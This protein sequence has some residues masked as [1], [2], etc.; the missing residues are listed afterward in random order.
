MNRPRS[1]R[2]SRF[3]ILSSLVAVAAVGCSTGQSEP[4][5]TSVAHVDDGSLVRVVSV[6]SGKVLDV[7]GASTEDGSLVQQ[8]AYGGGENQKWIIRDAGGG[9]FT[10]ASVRSGKCLDVAGASRDDGARLQQWSCSGTPNQG[11]ALHP[12]P[13][14]SFE[15][16]AAGSE[17]CLDLS[18]ANAADGT[19][20]QQWGCSGAANQRWRIESLGAPIPSPGA[21]PSMG[22][23]EVEIASAASGKVLDVSGASAANGAS[24][25]QWSAWGGA[26]QRWRIKPA[27][28][29]LYTITSV[30]H[31]ECLDVAGA[32]SDDGARL[33]QWDCSGAPNQAFRLIAGS[34]GAYAISSAASDKCL[35]LPGGGTDDGLFVQQWACSGASN[36][37]WLLRAAAGMPSP[38][39]PPQ[40]VT[41]LRAAADR[42]GR[43][44]GTALSPS[45][46]DDPSYGPTAGRE[47]NVVTPENE[48]KWDATE[49][50]PGQFDFAGGD[51]VVAFARQNGMKIKGHALVWHNQ[52]PGWAASLTDPAAVRA[53]MLRHIDAVASHYRGQLLSWDVVNEAIDDGNGN[54]IRDD[55]FHQKLGDGYIAEAFRAAHVAD[56][57]AL[58]FYNDYGIEGLGGKADAAY[59]LVRS[60][61]QQG[62]PISGV[63]L[64]MHIG[65]NG[66]PSAA[67]IA[68][69]MRR[70]AALGLLVNV[71]EMDTG[72]CEVAGDKAAKFGAESARMHDVVAACVL[73]SRCV[74]VTIWGVTDKYSWLNG[75]A[76]CDGGAGQTGQP[77]GLVFDDNYARK[78]AWQGIVDAFSGR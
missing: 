51:A 40:N 17:K 31:E 70:I 32:S 47:F 18:G 74:G 7:S 73:E 20:I 38:P 61:V 56:P 30:A 66:S 77:W 1:L 39:P 62:V 41:S 50:Q 76:P 54:A 2:R 72:V 48:M 27:G 68:A 12:A 75:F 19:P 13:D 65:A 46:F 35:D 5:R 34:T 11:F 49:P 10:F 60:L 42:A 55:V 64:Q 78:P 16:I 71:S 8:W 4:T 33:Q 3:W 29:G 26:N 45:H 37:Q 28:G 44:I 14:G 52:L 15:V 58:L 21:D 6:S 25:Q 24:I 43:F 36:Q 57:G 22:G 53:A 69:N 63:G 59:A 67:D 9:V 23:A